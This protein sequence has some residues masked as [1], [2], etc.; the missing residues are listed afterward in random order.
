MGF[1]DRT[2]GAKCVHYEREIIETGKG[3]FV[4]KGNDPKNE[5]DFNAVA[6]SPGLG[7]GAIRVEY[8]PGVIT[9]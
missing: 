3:Y 4:L 5:A 7:T 8:Y 2:M 1:N 9:D 6:N